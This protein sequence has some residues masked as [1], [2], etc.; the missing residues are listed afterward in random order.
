M[1]NGKD[2]QTGIGTS[3]ENSKISSDLEIIK[4]EMALV[5]Q[6]LQFETVLKER[7]EPMPYIPRS[8]RWSI[9]HWA[10]FWGVNAATVNR[11]NEIIGYEPM[12]YGGTKVVDAAK[13]W[14]RLEDS[15]GGEDG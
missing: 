15:A 10:V 14:K 1:T 2:S 4:E 6:G 11:N 5:Q 8:G 9:D 3:S 7:K 13:F 12:K